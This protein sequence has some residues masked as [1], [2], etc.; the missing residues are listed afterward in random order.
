[1]AGT[2]VNNQVFFDSY[3]GTTDYSGY[4][5]WSS[6][7]S[8]KSTDYKAVT[9]S[10]TS[11][12][13]NKIANGNTL[14]VA[15]AVVGNSFKYYFE[16]VKVLEH[17]R[18]NSSQ[19][20]GYVG[21]ASGETV[22]EVSNFKI[23]DLSELSNGV[24]D[25]ITSDTYG[26]YVS[27][28]NISFNSAAL[29]TDKAEVII[30]EDSTA[31]ISA[32]IAKDGSVVAAKTV[33]ETSTAI[34][35]ATATIANPAAFNLKVVYVNGTADIIVDGASVCLAH[36]FSRIA[37]KYGF[38]S[39]SAT[40]SSYTLNKTAQ[41]V[42]RVELSSE[43]ADIEYNTVSPDWS[44][45]KLDYVMSDGSK[46]AQ[47]V[48]DSMIEGYNPTESGEQTLTL[49]CQPNGKNYTAQFKVKVKADPSSVV[50]ARIG[51]ISDVHIGA[52]DSNKTALVN[53]LNYYKAK[54]VDAIV[55]V[56]DIGHDRVS[57]MDEFNTLYESVF[58]A[59]A[60]TSPEKFFVMGNH[61]TYAFENA[62]Y[63]R[64]TTGH[65]NAVSDYFQNTF[66]ITADG[67]TVGLNYYK[68][69]KGYVFVGL[70]IQTPIA[71]REAI[72]EEACALP[73]A[74]N[75]PVFVVE[76]EQPWGSNYIADTVSTHDQE[77][78]NVLKNYP[79][80]ITMMGHQ[81]NPLADERAIWQGEYTILTCGALFGP[82]VEENMYEG[83]SVNG[84]F[85]PG[86]WGAK[87]ALYMEVGETKVNVVRYD[88]THNEKLGKD[89]VIPID[90]DGNVDRTPYN[91][92]NRKA[93]AV[94][95]EF[96][97]DAALTATAIS[98]SI[99]Q[100]SWPKAITVYEDMDDIIQSYIIRAYDK[101][102]DNLVGEKRVISQHY[103]GRNLDNDTYSVNFNGLNS[104]TDYRFEVVAV[105]S[106]Q[107]ESQP[108]T[109]DADTKQFSSEGL[110]ATFYANF[111]YDWD[112]DAFSFYNN[113]TSKGMK[114]S[115]GA[116]VSDAANSSKAIVND[117]TFSGGTIETLISMNSTG[118]ILSA[119]IYLFASAPGN[120]MDDITAYNVHIESA[121]GS[122]DLHVY[123]YQFSGKYDGNRASNTVTDFF[124]DGNAKGSVVLKVEVTDGIVSVFANNSLVLTYTLSSTTLSGQVGLRTHFS[125]VDFDYI[126]IIDRNADVVALDLTELESL[127]SQAESKL[128]TTVGKPSEVF[129]TESCVS[130]SVMNALQ[131]VLD[132]YDTDLVRAYKRHVD[133]VVPIL[134]SA[135]TS[136]EAGITQ[137][138]KHSYGEWITTKEAT[139]DED[140]SAERVCA[141][142]AKETMTIPATGSGSGSNPS[143]PSGSDP[144]NPSGGIIDS[145]GASE[146]GDSSIGII[147]GC[148]VGGAIVVISGV[149]V[150]IIVVKKRKNVVKNGKEEND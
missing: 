87:S 149:A 119:G 75:K 85:Q 125:G 97:S 40:C 8:S 84:S 32:S 124:A 71:E 37:S 130:S 100:L 65:N 86:N 46:V 132:K 134:R 11:P 7:S 10:S 128:D 27:S 138:S 105:E 28:S 131:S 122:K 14:H 58:P 113:N 44:G 62:G 123:I 140:G 39:E 31:K 51:I 30:A 38:S 88:F 36:T 43:M 99:I 127:L 54:N 112:K 126:R 79:N 110:T 55:C 89:W 19:D 141:C 61:D 147:I 111:D 35:T 17:T 150:A 148:S 9:L 106:Y 94:A 117:V 104:S 5:G 69:I 143:V 63:P 49:T 29:D 80:V 15:L 60:P 6:T 3:Y 90:S 102:N 101:S 121:A 91:Y 107:V 118:S 22:L 48:S 108:I 103:L 92:N 34:A 50:N 67:G 93:T 25:E 57:Y 33:G 12:A 95:P 47:T 70:Y 4:K 73:E 20:T 16:G 144:S 120:G 21:F 136:F 68:V 139:A 115:D 18:T 74:Q 26:N 1:M 66:G 114:V 76:H 59:D 109:I 83:G 2:R 24:G 81:H 78:H 77:I 72:L 96:A 145:S 52:N 23:T 146:D 42:S 116:I 56:G 129:C 133:K 82:I 142:G 137:G 53:A 41:S 98:E 135:L 45:V 64:M 13:Y